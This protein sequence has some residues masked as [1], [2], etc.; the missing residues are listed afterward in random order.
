MAEMPTVVPMPTYEDVAR[1]SVWL[2][3]AFGFSE[4]ERYTDDGRVTTA[5]LAAGDGMILLGFA[6]PEYRSPRAHAE[7]CEQ[8]RKWAE[9]P[10]VIDGVLVHVD[11][12]R[13][14]YERATRAGATILSELEETDH[15]RRYR[16]ADP[17]GHRWMFVERGT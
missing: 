5:V 7:A 8:A 17:E 16:A 13:E 2:C 12:A 14:H 15:G 6:T 11:D 10:Y 9:V 1:A 3:D 4:R